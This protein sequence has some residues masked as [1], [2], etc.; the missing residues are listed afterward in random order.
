MRAESLRETEKQN[1]QE[2]AQHTE[3]KERLEAEK[4]ELK[5]ALAAANDRWEEMQG[6]RSPRVRLFLTDILLCLPHAGWAGGNQ[7]EWP[8]CWKDPNLSQQ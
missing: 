6:G 1:L 4:A 5:A 8:Q 2:I 3:V 7:A